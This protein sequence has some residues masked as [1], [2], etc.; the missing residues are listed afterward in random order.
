MKKPKRKI[1]EPEDSLTKW[2]RENSSGNALGDCG[3]VSQW[4]ERHGR[5]FWG[6][7]A[8]GYTYDKDNQ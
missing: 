8:H 1:E 7:E 2:W 5:G 6:C 4:E 3:S